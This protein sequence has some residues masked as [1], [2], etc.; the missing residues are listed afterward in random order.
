MV[1]SAVPGVSKLVP[2]RVAKRQVVFLNFKAVT[3]LTATHVL[4]QWLH[5]L[6]YSFDDTDL[7]SFI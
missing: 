5:T 1:R 3:S 4:A 6:F 7:H 2:Y